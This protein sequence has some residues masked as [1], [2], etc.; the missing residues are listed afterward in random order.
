MTAPTVGSLLHDLDARIEAADTYHDL[1]EAA[2]EALDAVAAL[3][4]TLTGAVAEA[5]W[6]RLAQAVSDLD[7]SE[8]TSIYRRA[9]AVWDDSYPVEPGQ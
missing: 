2:G 3:W 5:S 8:A 1:H 6:R 7:D 4:S 9:R